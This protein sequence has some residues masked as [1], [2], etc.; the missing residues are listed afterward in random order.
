MGIQVTK[1]EADKRV[2]DPLEVRGKQ[3]GF[4]YRWLR[5][6]DLNIARKKHA[7]YEIV[8]G[9]H[10]EAA[11]LDTSTRMKKGVDVDSTVQVGD[12]VLARI[13]IEKHEEYRKR[14]QDK[15]EHRTRGVARAYREAVG[16]MAGHEAGY[17][18]HR[19]S[20]QMDTVDEDTFARME[21]EAQRRRQ[22]G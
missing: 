17:T 1:D 9:D 22:R 3:P 14:N 5:K 16:R 21:A 19:D 15:I 20:P 10:P 13:P 8:Q 2:Q 18:E 11:T 7:G 12:L 6:S 4:H